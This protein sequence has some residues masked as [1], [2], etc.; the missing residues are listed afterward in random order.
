MK[1]E[2]K[3]NIAPKRLIAFTKSFRFPPHTR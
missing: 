3:E 2:E 1:R